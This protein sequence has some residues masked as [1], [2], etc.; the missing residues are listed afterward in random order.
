MSWVLKSLTGTEK[1]GKPLYFDK[2]TGIGPMTTPMLNRAQHFDT[3][4]EALRS[5]ACSHSL[6][7]YDAVLAEDEE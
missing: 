2:M 7:V 6:S 5:P 3:K 1:V 4:E